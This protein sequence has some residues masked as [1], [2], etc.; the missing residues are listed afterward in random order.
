MR[1]PPE[2]RPLLKR[3][4]G[5]LFA[6]TDAAVEHLR[7]LR[8]TRLIAVGDI[9]A[10]ELLAAGLKPDI[11]IVDF[12]V[13]RAPASEDIRRAIDAHRAH[14][15]RVRNPAGTITPE[16]RDALETASPPAK[17][18]VD[19]EEDLSVLPAVLAA[20]VGSVVAYGQPNEG[21]VLVMV[22]EQKKREFR[23]LLKLFK[24]G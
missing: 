4:L 8:P 22:T 12:R 20:P 15:L 10:A 24:K 1:L 2:V 9:T 23:G 6:K 19:G 16:L 13:M 18:I 5:E 14:V 7:K 17:I 11:A 21:L 3:P